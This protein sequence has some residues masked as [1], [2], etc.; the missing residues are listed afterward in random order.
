[1][2]E[3]IFG[4]AKAEKEVIDLV[5]EFLSGI[6]NE[7]VHV[8]LDVVGIA[9]TD[10]PLLADFSEVGEEVVLIDLLI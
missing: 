6:V 7:V 8:F 1:M 9:I 10:G 3:G 4:D 5:L 2:V